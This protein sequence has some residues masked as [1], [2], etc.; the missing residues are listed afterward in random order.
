[1]RLD[2]V[3][4]TPGEYSAAWLPPVTG[5]YRAAARARH[6]GQEIGLSRFEFASGLAVSAWASRPQ[7]EVG[8]PVQL[9]ARVRDN[10]NQPLSDAKIAADIEFPFAVARK[11]VH[12]RDISE[13]RATIEFSAMADAPGEYQAHWQPPAPG[14]YRATVKAEADAAGKGSYLLEFV[15]G[16]SD[17]EF[18]TLQVDQTTL[19][20][21][22]S[23]TD[24]RPYTQATAAG[25]PEELDARRQH[26]RR[27]EEITLWNAPW[28][29]VVL[30]L[31]ATSEWI[32]RK[33]R[34]LS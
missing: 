16:N 15:V 9:R 26:E 8:Q 27:Y 3:A 10:E 2:A 31:C 19:R 24:G 1:V 32:L 6:R 20:T 34:A 30:L 25:I 17:P 12:G 18:R 11:G 13:Q 7:Y 5:L 29:F 14:L 22:A 28:F 4:G 33:R 21:L 23:A